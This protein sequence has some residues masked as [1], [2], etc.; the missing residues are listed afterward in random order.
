MQRANVDLPEPDSPTMPS[1]APFG[2]FSDTFL[3]AAV[4]RAPRP[5][6]PPLRYVLE[7]PEMVRMFSSDNCRGGGAFSGGTAAMSCLV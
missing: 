6:K 3:T 2:R 1:V 5:K 7:T 4:T